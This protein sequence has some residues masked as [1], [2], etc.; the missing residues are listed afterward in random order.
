MP[1]F[2]LEIP[3]G[4]DRTGTEYQSMGRYYDSDLV[5]WFQGRI[6][7][8]GGWTS[9]STG[10]TGIARAMHNWVDNSAVGRAAIGTESKLYVVTT[11]GTRTDITPSGYVAQDADSST[12]GLDSSGQLL[13]GCND[14]EGVIY[15][16]TPGAP[17]ALTLA[18][19]PSADGVL[20]TNEGIIMALGSAGNPRQ[21]SW[22]DRD[23]YTD[24]SA[25]PVDLAGDLVV[26][27]KGAIQGGRN[28]RAGS[29]VWTGEDLHLARYVGLPNVYGID[30]VAD[31]CGAI[32]RGCMVT[33][34]NMAYWMGHSD[35]FVCN[36]GSFVETIPCL[37]YDDVFG[38]LD[39]DNLHKI[40]AIHVAEYN[41]IWWLYPHVD[42]AGT[43]N[44]RVAVFNYKENHWGWH[45]LARNCGIGR[46]V[47]FRQPLLAEGATLWTHETGTSRSGVGTPFARSG[48]V[49][50][51]TGEKVMHARRCIPDEAS[52]GDVNVYFYTRLYPNSAE[53]EHGPYSAANPVNVR[54][55]GRQVSMKF[56]EASPSDW[57]VG[58][59][60][61]EALAGGRR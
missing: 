51:G 58:N 35:F 10:M 54:F 52:A 42:D 5:R 25:G 43:N 2:K 48:P 15:T 21:V 31:D 26:H 11:D 47:G 17:L 1:F 8:I 45:K 60:R 38:D 14:G 18:N 16:W 20:V 13:I 41:E 23:D 34:D 19:A 37:I 57:R 22:C 28:I 24:W 3:P 56:Q 32:S 9:L 30:L 55:M 33:V 44:S 59:Y 50:I 27:A 40:R 7:A 39:R 61:I 12:W 29:L 49:E 46:G 6:R 53:T 36:G 4:L